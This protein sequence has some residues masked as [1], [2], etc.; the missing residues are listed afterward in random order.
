LGLGLMLLPLA[1]PRQASAQGAT[2]NQSLPQR[3]TAFAANLSNVQAGP[4]AQTVEI[5]ITRWSTD[6]ERDRLLTA[7]KEKGEKALLSELQKMSKVGTIRTPNSL[8]YELRFAR[9]H[10]YGDGGRRIF[11]ATDRYI[12]YWE[13]TNNTRSMDYPFTLIEMRLDNHNQGEGKLSLATKVMA[14]EDQI[15]LED[16]ANQPVMLKNVKE[17][18]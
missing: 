5:Q 13:V 18:K 14:D 6:A 17:E 4:A 7:L 8:G 15:V 16:Y 11:I 9:Q 1:Q 2:L 3:F 12:N 10:P